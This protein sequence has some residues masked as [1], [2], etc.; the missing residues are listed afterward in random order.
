MPYASV[1]SPLGTPGNGLLLGAACVSKVS[2]RTR[3]SSWYGSRN[4]A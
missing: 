3:A 4:T 2:E 1:G